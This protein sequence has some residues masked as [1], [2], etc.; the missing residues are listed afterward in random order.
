[1]TREEAIRR[2]KAWNLNSDD[3]EVLAVIIPELAE[4]EDERIRKWII[5]YARGQIDG[6][7]LVDDDEAHEIAE[8]WKKA[9]AYLEKQKEPKSIS[10]EEVLVR[11]GL[12]PYKDG[13][14]WCIL[15]GD[16]IQ[17]GICGFGDTIDEA[18]YEFLM[19]VLEKQEKTKIDACGFPI[20]NEGESACSYLERCLSPDM[21]KIWYEACKEM[22]EKLTPID[23]VFGFKIGDKVR[24][25]DGDGRP[26]IIK[27]F[28]RIIGL[29][30][31]DFYQVIFEDDSAID[32]II[33]DDRCQGG[34]F[35]CMEKIP[36]YEN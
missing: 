19:E 20:R 4:S 10:A 35:T 26:H 21:R 31:P 24:L 30:G 5:D 13:N 2:I 23:N 15:A 27:E 11:A 3:R 34:Y 7:M 16:N 36:E 6:Y 33:P 12:I 32:H 18:L 17:E 29:H 14:K 1:M 28:K 22:K 8:I 9:I 25:R